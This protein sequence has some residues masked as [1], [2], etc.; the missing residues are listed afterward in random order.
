M[1][2]PTAWVP[3][4]D[5]IPPEDKEPVLPHA[6]KRRSMSVFGG[7]PIEPVVC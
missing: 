3:L 2:F 7:A 5:V 6:T 4:Y 1:S